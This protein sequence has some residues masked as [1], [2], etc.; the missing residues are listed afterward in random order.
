MKY[1]FLILL[2]GA[3]FGPPGEKDDHTWGGEQT[4]HDGGWDGPSDDIGIDDPQG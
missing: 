4:I 2:I 1:W 3:L